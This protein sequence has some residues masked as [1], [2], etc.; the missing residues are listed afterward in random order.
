M[1][2]YSAIHELPGKCW[3]QRSLYCR[4]L[5]LATIR[6]ART[7]ASTDPTKSSRT[8]R[9]LPIRGIR[10][11]TVHYTLTT[12]S[13]ELSWTAVNW[14]EMGSS[15]ID[16]HTGPLKLLH[17]NVVRARNN[18]TLNFVTE[19]AG[20]CRLSSI[21]SGQAFY[22][23]FATSSYI[24]FVIAPVWATSISAKSISA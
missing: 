23:Y 24:Q 18:A 12:E 16:D 17:V 21:H 11:A 5:R 14:L 6:Y 1:T 7:S 15:S 9:I 2:R 8:F 10:R 4:C 13:A 20:F 3:H 19:V 22:S